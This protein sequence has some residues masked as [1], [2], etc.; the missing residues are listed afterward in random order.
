MSTDKFRSRV[1]NYGTPVSVVARRRARHADSTASLVVVLVF[2]ALAVM[3]GK[4]GLAVGAELVLVVPQ[5]LFLLPA[6]FVIGAEFLDV[7]RAGGAKAAALASVAALGMVVPR[8]AGG[9]RQQNDRQ[10]GG[11]RRE[12]GR[13]HGDAEPLLFG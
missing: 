5:A 10:C 11:A 4:C 13:S 3:L 12:C 9:D 1:S 2:P 6:L 7:G 8:T